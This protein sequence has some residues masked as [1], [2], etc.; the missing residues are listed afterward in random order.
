M[1]TVYRNSIVLL[2]CLSLS[3][4]LAQRLQVS[5]T[6]EPKKISIGEQAKLSLNI[7]YDNNIKSNDISWPV[8]KDTINKNIEILDSVKSKKITDDGLNSETTIYTITSF[9]SGYYAIKPFT[10]SVQNNLYE[11][12]ALLFEVHTV[13]TDTTQP[14]KDIK[15]IYEEQLSFNEY[16]KL[17]WDWL[18]ENWYIS[19]PAFLA[20]CFLIW[21]FFIRKKQTKTVIPVTPKIPAHIRALQ[22]INELEKNKPWHT[23]DVKLFY[24]EL[25]DI[26]RK[27]IEERFQIPAL[28]KTTDEI[29]HAFR[30][31]DLSEDCKM[32][33]RMLLRL[34]DLV[35]FAKEKPLESENLSAIE[36]AKEF[37]LI[38]VPKT[39]HD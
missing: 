35:K 10:F 32:K 27:Y 3:T 23:G 2:F 21:Y 25:T 38:T 29:M 4:V 5:A 15:D 6:I 31:S 16:I 11:T 34:A 36:Q 9:D 39:N 8:L 24:V 20:L 14:I 19:L 7:R 22:M 13:E 26:I 17:F 28:E 1:Q 37:V 18:I 12:P 33:L 30:L